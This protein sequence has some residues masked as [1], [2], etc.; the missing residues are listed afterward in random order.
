MTKEN[1]AILEM[2]I[3]SVMWSI[4]GIFIKLVPWH[5][6]AIT[7]MRSLIAGLTLLVYMAVKRHKI[8][9]NKRTLI[10]GFFM[11]SV[12]ITFVISNKLTT[13]SNAIVLQFI[14]PLFIVIFSALL[15]RQK[16][17]RND[18]I[19]VVFTMLGIVLCFMDGIGGGQLLGNVCAIAAGLFSA[20]MYISMGDA[21]NEERFSSL[22]TGHSFAF[23]FGLPFFLTTSPDISPLPVLYVF[24]LGVFQLGIPYILYAR[25]SENCAPL[26][27]CLISAVEPLLN[28]V[29]VAI[30][31]GEMPGITALIGG[32][33][34]IASVTVW[35][36][37]GQAE[38]TG[39]KHGHA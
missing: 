29:W 1:R 32:V 2:F 7:S 9:C 37:Y 21:T 26:A 31:D 12:Y 15:F 5:G 18:V 3:C 11:G 8:I 23:L 13:A 28:P 27:C 35:C 34:V 17:R 33:I 36:A 38:R 30:F 6:F 20:G 10:T 25:A 39:K 14:S 19:A 24:I 4:S 22:L 16:I